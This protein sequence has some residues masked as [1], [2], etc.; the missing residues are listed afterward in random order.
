MET[1]IQRKVVNYRGI[2]VIKDIF[3]SNTNEEKDRVE[4]SNNKSKMSLKS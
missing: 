4:K 1:S 3:K 2:Q